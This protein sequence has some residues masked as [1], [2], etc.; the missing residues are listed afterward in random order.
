ME[1]TQPVSEQAAEIV[2]KAFNKEHQILRLEFIKA[3]MQGLISNPNTAAVSVVKLRDGVASMS[4]VLGEAT[5]AEAI[6]PHE[7][8][9]H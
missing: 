9:S 6:K 5:L 1:K 8:E 2:R 7:H 3:A 4:V